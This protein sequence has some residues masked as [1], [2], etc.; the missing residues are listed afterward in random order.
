M[1]ADR[2]LLFDLDTPRERY[3]VRLDGREHLMA[4]FDDLPVNARRRLTRRYQQA[5]AVEGRADLTDAEIVEYEAA[6]SEVVRTVFP[7]IDEAQVE[8]MGAEVREALATAF[9]TS[10]LVHHVMQRLAAATGGGPE[11]E[12]PHPTGREPSPVSSGS[13]EPPTPPT[14]SSESLSTS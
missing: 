14:G 7:S 10:R 4:T 8:A 11:P 13:T 9:F 2:L 3:F 5:I 6:V 12:T 1:T